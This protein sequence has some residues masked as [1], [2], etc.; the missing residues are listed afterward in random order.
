[1]C[2]YLIWFCVF[3]LML[4]NI[5]GVLGFII[6]FEVVFV[7]NQFLNLFEFFIERFVVLGMDRI[8]FIMFFGLEDSIRIYFFYIILVM[9]NEI[10]FLSLL[11]KVLG[12]LRENNMRDIFEVMGWDLGKVLEYVEFWLQ[13][14]KVLRERLLLLMERERE[15][16]GMKIREGVG[17]GDCQIVL[18][19]KV[20]GVLEGVRDVLM[21]GEEGEE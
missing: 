1:M 11:V 7:L 17:G 19:E 5:F 9:M 12:V 6:V 2:C 16:W 21:V 18:E 8:I 15:W 13:S 14:R 20:V 10:Y 3:L 4:I